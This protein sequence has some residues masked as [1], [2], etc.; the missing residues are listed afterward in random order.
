[1]EKSRVNQII[2]KLIDSVEN[3][4]SVPLSAGKVMVNKDE[5]A[6]MLRELESIVNG[7]LRTYREVNDRKGKIITEAKKEAEEIIYEAEQ[8]ASRIRVTKRVSSLGG[9]FRADKLD[10][11]DRMALRTATDIYAASLIYTDEMLTEVNDLL[12]QAYDY[13]NNQY[14]RM[15][16]DLEEKAKIIADNKAELMVNLKELSKEERYEQ[17]LELAQLLSNELYSERQKLKE[18]E[19]Y[20]R[21]KEEA[22]R[23]AGEIKAAREHTE[24]AAAQKVTT[25]KTAAKRPPVQGIAGKQPSVQ[26]VAGKQPPAQEAAGKRSTSHKADVRP[27]VPENINVQGTQAEKA[28]AEEADKKE[29]ASKKQE[30]PDIPLSEAELAFMKKAAEQKKAGKIY[31]I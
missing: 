31:G 3:G 22:A 15:I 7:E 14:G 1:M 20:D 12:A 19:T 18:M 5:T 29:E 17:I 24:K 4:Q 13:V 28:D 21:K 27:D 11:E 30:E 23:L 25:E 9:T 16:L 10:N 6:L 2:D 8:T 26:G